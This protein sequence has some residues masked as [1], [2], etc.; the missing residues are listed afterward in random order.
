METVGSSKSGAQTR[1]FLPNRAA[2]FPAELGWYSGSGGLGKVGMASQRDCQELDP[3]VPMRSGSDSLQRVVTCVRSC[4]R[5]EVVLPHTHDA[6][7]RLIG[8]RYSDRITCELLNRKRWRT[9][10]RLVVS[11]VG[12]GAF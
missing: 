3:T 8:I 10:I 5:L 11:D 12:S 9:V 1:T 7:L 6:S 4:R 2:R